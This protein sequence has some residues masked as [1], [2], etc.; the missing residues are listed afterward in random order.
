MADPMAMTEACDDGNNNDGDGCA[1]L[2]TIELGYLCPPTRA[3][4]LPKCGDGLLSRVKPAT[5]ATTR[6]RRLSLA[7]ALESGWACSG[8]ASPV[9]RTCVATGHRGHRDLR[10]RLGLPWRR[11][12]LGLPARDRLG[13]HRRRC[14]AKECGDGVVAGDRGLRR[15]QHRQRR[16]VSPT[17][18]ARNPLQLP[19]PGWRLKKYTKCG[20]GMPT[21][22]EECGPTPTPLRRRLSPACKVEANWTCPG[23]HQLLATVLPAT[24]SWPATRSADERRTLAPGCDANCNLTLHVVPSR[25]E[26]DL[27]GRRVRPGTGMGA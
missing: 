2:C 19:C 20:D 26:A 12:Q 18:A 16:R 17:A 9:W 1:R 25:Q 6:T 3:R 27:H 7:C 22:D 5:T 8:P 14:S 23:G 10:R 11:L 21:P 24:A 13:L 15:P 4:V